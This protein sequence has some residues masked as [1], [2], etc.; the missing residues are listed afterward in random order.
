M[1]YYTLFLLFY[2]S[3][4]PKALY[5]GYYLQMYITSFSPGRYSQGY[6]PRVLLLSEAYDIEDTRQNH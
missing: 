4:T 5:S 3:Y 2:N 6:L 1:V